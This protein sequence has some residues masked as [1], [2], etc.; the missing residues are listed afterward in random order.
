VAIC[1]TSES[2]LDRAYADRVHAAFARGAAAVIAH[3][4]PGDLPRWRS[5]MVCD[6]IER[7]VHSIRMETSP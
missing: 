2:P 3:S 1:L 4:L 6:D 5:L 7:G